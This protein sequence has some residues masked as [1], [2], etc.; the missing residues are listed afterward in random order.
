MKR[1]S[2]DGYH[3]CSLPDS[4]NTRAFVWFDTPPVGSVVEVPALKYSAVQSSAGYQFFYRMTPYQGLFGSDQFPGVNASMTGY[5]RAEG[6]ALVTTA[7][8]GSIVAQVT[9]QKNI[10]DRL[11]TLNTDK[12]ASG[13]YVP[14]AFAN[15]D[16]D[17]T[18]TTQI[19]SRI[20]DVMDSTEVIIGVS[21][22]P[23]PLAYRGRSRI[24][25]SGED[26]SLKM[27]KLTTAGTYQKTYQSYLLDKDCSGELYLVVV[28]SESD[29]GSTL[30]SFAGSDAVDIFRLPGRPLTLR[31]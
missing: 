3:I 10:I 31:K 6:P 28:G 13:D 18:L 29:N 2:V 14:I 7:G 24:T 17:P 19:V 5:F 21:S 4:S 15:T 20:H 8:S 30:R 9:G 12:D 26:L 1:Q 16:N 22:S 27:G 23:W 11:P 25:S